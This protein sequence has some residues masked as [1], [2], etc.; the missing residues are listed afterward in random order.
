MRRAAAFLAVLLAALALAEEPPRPSAADER[1]QCLKQCVG[2]PR[3][4]TGPVLLACL[5]RCEALAAPD[6][7]P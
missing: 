3:D 6:A 2:A 1:A 4:A 5:A 7:G